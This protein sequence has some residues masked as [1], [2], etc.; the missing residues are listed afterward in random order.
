MSGL[1]ILLL[2]V[3]CALPPAAEVALPAEF[4]SAEG[5]QAQPSFLG[6]P[7]D[8]PSVEAGGGIVTLGVN[9][10]GKGMKW[11]F[12]VQPFDAADEPYLVMRYRAENTAP[13][14]YVLWAYDGSQGGK[15][16]LNPGDIIRD[17]RWHVIALDLW[18]LDLVGAVREFVVEVQCDQQPA[19]FSLD[20]LRLAEEPPP[21]AQVHAPAA[22]ETPEWRL[23]FDNVEGFEPHTDWLGNPAEKFALVAENGLAH[24]S[25]SGSGKGMK[26]SLRLPDGP[27]LNDFRYAVLRYRARGVKAHGDY[28]VW[29][30]SETGGLPQQ[31]WSAFRL[32]EIE[33]DDTWHV[34]AA[35]ITEKFKVAELAIQI[36]A[37]TPQADLWLDYFVL[38]AQR[39]LAEIGDL[40]AFQSGWTKLRAPV[41]SF[42]CVDIAAACNTKAG[43]RLRAYGLKTW[44]PAGRLSVS[45]I[46]FVVPD[47]GRVAATARPAEEPLRIPVGAQADE[48]FLLMAVRLPALDFS[49]MLHGRPFRH[50][51]NPERFVARVRYED[52]AVD[53]VFPI[54]VASSRW[55]VRRGV[56]VYA[57]PVRKQQK[58]RE[59]ALVNHMPTGHFL[60]AALTAH[61]G[62]P[63]IREPAVTALPRP[64]KVA[65]GS[66]LVVPEK[67]PT[68]P[69]LDT[70]KVGPLLLGW[71]PKG[72]TGLHVRRLIMPT[73]AQIKAAFQAGALFEVGVG[74]KIIGSDQLKLGDL[75]VKTTTSR[76]GKQVRTTTLP[77]D[78][79]PA[80]VP[81][82]GELIATQAEGEPP[83]L[84]LRLRNS[85]DQVITPVVNFPVLRDVALGS[86]EDTWYLYTQRGGVINNAPCS[87][88]AP[89]SGLHPLQVEA[90]YNPSAGVGVLVLP[91]DVKDIY[92]FLHLEKTERGV[93]Y[94][95]EYFPR[96]YQPGEQIELAPT[97][98][99]A[100]RGDWRLPLRVY[101]EWARTWYR[102]QVPRKKWFQGCFNY[103]QHLVRGD[104]RDRKTGRFRFE[105]VIKADREFFGRLDYLHIFDFGASKRYGR[106]GDYSHYEE[107]GGREALAAAIRG[108][109]KEGVPIGLYIEGYLCDDRGVWGGK[110]VSKYDIRKKDG[111][112]LLWTGAPHEHMMCPAAVGWQDYLAA[113]YKRV[114]AELKPS[115]MYIDQ[116]GF[117]NT[118][119]ICYSRKHGHP[120]PQPPIRGEQQLDRKIRAAVPPE[121]A[122]LT[123]ETP[124]D[125]NSQFQDGALGYSVASANPELAPHRVDLFRFLFPDFKVFQLVAYNRFVEGGWHRLKFPFFNGEGYWLGNAIPGGFDDAARDFLRDAFRILNDYEDAFTS[126]DVECLIPTLAPLVY[127]NRFTGPKRTVWTLFNADY[128]TFRGEALAVPRRA[129]A[130]Y[131]D[132]F[133]Q[134]PIKPRLE[135]DQAC[136]TVTLGPR[137]VGCVVEER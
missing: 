131:L 33:A 117:G 102:P 24:L 72:H 28:C 137:A 15:A 50:F 109:Q 38:T 124:T 71:D 132:A 23:D 108:A 104:L 99:S 123:E 30:G 134:A 64:P 73:S 125:F 46:P 90:L 88:R 53:E 96:E 80:G 129:G 25:C 74:E 19:R 22:P 3:S 4:D 78:A 58:V 34:I 48:L 14:G 133:S 116:H 70:L 5:W 113:T 69:A 56:D 101:R 127:A 84:E 8:R 2:A 43:R 54:C 65:G 106:V 89:Y 9:E 118:W 60:V 16:I 35:P 122:T 76:D 57:L 77:V 61:S 82:A 135:G 91:Q 130:R 20:Y 42:D 100:F 39:P 94:S 40:L 6:N 79:R 29:L 62:A 13:R 128:K 52:N 45:G 36:Q 68:A 112:A 55:E 95:I 126:D 136:L 11:T 67:L 92:K 18:A 10:P 75:Q 107:I 111:S 32:T 59:L 93:S 105:E 114:C 87:L 27:D 17:G 98:V 121:V 47:E 12:A 7:A 31:F 103:R 51:S 37:A 1:A 119:K 120:V 110:N 66:R 44:L 26:W 81:L 86:V 85:S 115:G 97:V 21:G 83:T 63:L 41:Q 49:G